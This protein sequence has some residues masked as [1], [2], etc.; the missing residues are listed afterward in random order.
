MRCITYTC[1]Q[2]KDRVAQLYSFYKIIFNNHK[3]FKTI[4]TGY[5]G[6]ETHLS[7]YFIHCLAV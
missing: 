4:N 3:S 2:E 5:L 7:L 1:Y 6:A